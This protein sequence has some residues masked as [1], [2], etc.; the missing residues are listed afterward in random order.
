L[1]GVAPFLEAILFHYFVVL[2]TFFLGWLF[3]G[4]FAL[5]NGLARF[6]QLG[7]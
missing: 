2:A 7:L 3:Q 6:N 4:N 1:A 5:F